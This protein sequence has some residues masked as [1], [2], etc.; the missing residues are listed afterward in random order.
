M[1]NIN[2][3]KEALFGKF[4]NIG[5]TPSE[6]FANLLIAIIL[7]V[8]GIILGKIVKF[9]L[10]KGLEKIKIEKILKP[11]FVDLFLV[12]IKWSIYIL[13][14]DLALIQLEIPTIT[15]WLTTIL[16]VIPSLVGALIIISVGL[17][18]GS[19]LKNVITE[20]KIRDWQILSQIFFYF[21]MYIFIIFAFRTALISVRDTSLINALLI[22]FTA[23][24]GI[25]LI[26]YY[27]KGKKWK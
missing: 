11:S 8:I 23:L 27:L 17:A 5:I 12:I 16:T 9:G 19:Y 25:V 20:S 1:A 7:I 15:S 24:G 26:I 22:V 18:I 21:V 10:R 13:F 4:I 3:I 2:S 14:I 6:F